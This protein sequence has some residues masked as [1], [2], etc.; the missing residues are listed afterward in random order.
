MQ[1]DKKTSY[2]AADTI[3]VKMLL[4]KDLIKS[5]TEQRR[6]IPIHM[7]FSP[8]NKCNQNCK[9]CSCSK[10]N[11]NLEM[12]F[13]LAKKIIDKFAQLGTKSV[14]IT[15]GGEPLLYPKINELIDYF[16]KK[17]IKVGMVSNGRVLHTIPAE[18]LNK[19]VWCRISNDDGRTFTTEYES[20][21]YEAIK[22]GNKVDW[23][24]S[25]VVS[26]HP[27]YVEINKIVQFAN[28]HRFT[29]VR[30]VADLF[31]PEKV[32]MGGIKNYL[33]EKGIND[34]LVIYQ[35]RKEFIPGGDCYI[36]YLKP[37]IGSDGKLY[38]CCG[39]QYALKEPSRDLPKELCLGDALDI[40][41]IIAKSNIPF[42][43]QICVKC[44]YMNYNIILGSLLSEI[45]HKEFV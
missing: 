26:T 35:G 3:S 14:T 27:N 13:E 39:C 9:F 23:A 42:N 36:C 7:Q 40:D 29:H 5:A 41:K 8:T 19:V 34:D 25:Y 32:D 33:K 30:L 24:F 22:K 21:L 43:G 38:T 1:V 10:R 44:Y 4:D 45:K 12:D 17:Q 2:T 20:H 15:G 18:T 31:M 11:K 6:I 37:Y 16:Y 28:K